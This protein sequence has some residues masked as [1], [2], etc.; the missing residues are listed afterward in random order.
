MRTQIVALGNES[1]WST[2]IPLYGGWKKMP[3]CP[4][5]YRIR[6]RVGASWQMAYVGQ[7][8]RGG[9]GHLK[10]RLSA[11]RHVYDDQMP[12]K[13]PHAGGPPLWAW[14]QKQP[15]AVFDVSVVPLPDIPDAF[16]QGLETLAIA[17]CRQRD[18]HSPLCQFARMPEGYAPSSANNTRLVLAGKRKRGGPT[19]EQLDCH[20]P[21]IAPQGSLEGDPHARDWCGHRWTPWIPAQGLRPAGATGLYRLRVNGLDPLI[22]LGQGKLSERLKAIRPLARMECS[23]VANQGWQPHMRLELVTDSIAA[24]LWGTSTLPL[25]Q[26]EPE[27]PE[28][29]EDLALFSQKARRA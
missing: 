10:S 28:P 4:G 21:G 6:M 15:D 7:T 2:W 26:F 8:G 22:F 29:D 19:V 13:D 16:R 1:A 9:S 11:L 18:G 25:W 27:H 5:L 12:Y 23:W 3:A 20:R 24:H 17:L 14:R